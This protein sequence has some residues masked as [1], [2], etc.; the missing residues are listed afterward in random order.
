MCIHDVPK[1]ERVKEIGSNVALHMFKE[2]IYN[3]ID[4]DGAV[5]N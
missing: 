2:F 4:V 5:E 3:S 1:D